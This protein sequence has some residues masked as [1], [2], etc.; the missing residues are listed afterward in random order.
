MVSVIFLLSLLGAVFANSVLSRDTPSGSITSP[1]HSSAPITLSV[2]S[3]ETTCYTSSQ[4]LVISNTS[5]FW[6]TSTDYIYGPTTGP[7]ASDVICA[8]QWMQY[9]ERSRG[10]S[11]LGPTKTTTVTLYTPTST[12][13]CRTSIHPE[14]YSDTHT[15][16]VTT[17]CDG[18]ARAL[19]PRETATEYYPGTGPCSTF[20]E[21]RIA[22]TT[23]NREPSA[24]PTCRAELEGCIGVW[25]TYSSLSSEY[26]ASITSPIPGDT[27]SPLR[28]AH[29]PN[30]A[31]E[32]PEENPCSECHFIPGTATMFYWPVTTA[33]GDLCA[34]NGTTIPAT[35][36]GDG[37]NTAILDTYTLVSPSVY[38]SFTSINAWSNRR[39]GHQCGERYSNQLISIHPTAV[40]SLREHRNAR[41]PYEGTPYPFN[42]AEFLPQTIG[43]FTQSLIPW[44]QYRGGSQCPLYDPS[45]TMVRDD[46]MP[47]IE[48]PREAAEIDSHWERCSRRWLVPAVTMVPIVDGTAVAPTPTGEME[49][50]AI[51]ADA[52]PEG[53]VEAPTPMPTAEL[54]W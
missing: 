4:W 15:G 28:P 44:P 40:T 10:L 18:V 34:Q 54:G 19:G 33:N 48:V 25:Q 13:A 30:T 16:P 27:R 2:P 8:A 26:A 6:P 11:S 29:C 45:C 37:P 38:I 31:R 7:G 21:S 36:T 39:H 12:G 5:V 46:Y 20:S 41:Y 43:N 9:D 14:Q 23:V 22:T 51:E 17:L 24:S 52:V 32:Y 49:V 47:F 53:M 1:V 50:M 35:Q 42:F 3:S